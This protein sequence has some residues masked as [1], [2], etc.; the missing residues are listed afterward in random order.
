[1]RAP[2]KIALSVRSSSL[3]NRIEL[4]ELGAFAGPATE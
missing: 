1:M 2:V 4:H 3:A